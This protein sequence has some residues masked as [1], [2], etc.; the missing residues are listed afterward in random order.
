MA[1]GGNKKEPL[2]RDAVP[3]PF[4]GELAPQ[5]SEGFFFSTN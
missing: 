4:T 5:A 3:L 1:A 2:H